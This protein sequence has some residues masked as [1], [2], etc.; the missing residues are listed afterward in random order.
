LANWLNKVAIV[1]LKYLKVMKQYCSGKYA[2][3]HIYC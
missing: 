3:Q 1:L 2:S